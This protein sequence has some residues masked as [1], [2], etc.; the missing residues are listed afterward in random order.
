MGFGNEQRRTYASISNGKFFIKCQD[1]EA[2]KPDVVEKVRGAASPNAGQKYYGREYGKVD[3]LFTG[4]EVKLGNYG[5]ELTI[6]LD[7]SIAVGLSCKDK[8]AEQF[9][10][11]L[12]NIDLDFAIYL[13]P[14]DYVSKKTGKRTTGLG[15]MQKGKDVEPACTAR[16]RDGK[17]YVDNLPIMPD[18]QSVDVGGPKPL[19]TNV[20]RIKWLMSKYGEPMIQA[21]SM[22]KASTIG[23]SNTTTQEYNTPPEFEDGG[24]DWPVEDDE[25]LV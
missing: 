6:E 7:N 1:S 19:L 8:H 25:P 2:G 9:L 4:L 3:G 10:A 23:S 21:L 17:P 5:Q 14:Y 22:R 20:E 12:P 11:A 15:I 16:D 24:G 13:K 18:K